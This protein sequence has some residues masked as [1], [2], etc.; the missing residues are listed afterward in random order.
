MNVHPVAKVAVNVVSAMVTAVVNVASVVVNAAR[1]TP[2][3]AMPMPQSQ[4]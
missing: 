1:Q 2:L 3:P 4:Q